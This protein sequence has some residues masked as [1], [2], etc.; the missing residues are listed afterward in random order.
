[1]LNKL[2]E[3]KKLVITVST[4]VIVIIVMVVLFVR[5]GSDGAQNGGSNPD[6][7][8]KQEDTYDGDGL[9]I[10][11]DDG[12]SENRADT[13]EYWDGTPKSDNA[14]KKNDDKT[15]DGQTTNSQ[16]PGSN[17]QD[18]G[19]TQGGTEDSASE[20]G[21]SSGDI[22]KDADNTSWGGIY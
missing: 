12:K 1:M 9:E 16:T 15:T 22:P 6:G 2:L 13:S 5:C 11:E 14:D 7:N 19:T 10:I 8:P 21:V 3:N 17:T 4:I 20:D 18:N